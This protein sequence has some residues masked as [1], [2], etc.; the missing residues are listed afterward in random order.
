MGWGGF[1][2][3]FAWILLRFSD[4]WVD[5]HHFLWKI[6]KRNV[7]TY[8]FAVPQCSPLPLDPGCTMWDRS[9]LS[10]SHR[11]SAPAFPVPPLLVAHSGQLRPH[12]LQV[13]WPF[14]WG[15]SP[16][17]NPSGVFFISGV[18]RPRSSTLVSFVNLP[19]LPLSCPNFPRWC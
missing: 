14:P 13:P 6:L 12:F 10:S 7:W 15:A 2:C 11:D 18:S 1:L 19:F 17:C 4:L 5:G 16:G 3:S 9:A 8:L